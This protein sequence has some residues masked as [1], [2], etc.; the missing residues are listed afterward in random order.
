MR[1]DSRVLFECEPM[2]WIL[3]NKIIDLASSAKPGGAGNYLPALDATERLLGKFSHGGCALLVAFLSDGRPSDHP[4]KGTKLK[5]D[6]AMVVDERNDLGCQEWNALGCDARLSA[7]MQDRVFGMACEFGKRLNFGTIAIAEHGLPP[8]MARKMERK[9]KKAGSRA[10]G[11]RMESNLNRT[12]DEEF[13]V[14]RGMAEAAKGFAT[15]SFQTAKN[16][17]SQAIVSLTD[18]YR[19]DRILSSLFLSLSLFLTLRCC[20]EQ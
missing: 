11:K 4:P 9:R 12:S 18:R 19:L 20:D 6:R 15:S 17:L 5:R 14:L 3:F 13:V 16:M 10:R 1:N 7:L 2:D 8:A